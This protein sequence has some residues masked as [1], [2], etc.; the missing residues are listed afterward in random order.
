VDKSSQIFDSNHEKKTSYFSKGIDPTF[1]TIDEKKSFAK[2]GSDRK[3]FD[4][5]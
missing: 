2:I 4:F 5:K 3:A 1:L